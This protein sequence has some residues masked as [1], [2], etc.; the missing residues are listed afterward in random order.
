MLLMQS[1]LSLYRL[2]LAIFQL[3]LFSMK[4]ILEDFNLK[5]E[6]DNNKSINNTRVLNK[7]IKINNLKKLLYLLTIM[8]RRWMSTIKIVNLFKKSAYDT[9]NYVW[10]FYWKFFL[11]V[12]ELIADLLDSL[13]VSLCVWDMIADELC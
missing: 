2:T 10:L 6:S 5:I 3:F 9:S 8:E 7:K 1:S 4:S 11:D 12:S 13:G